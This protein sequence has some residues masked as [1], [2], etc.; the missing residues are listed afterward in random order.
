MQDRHVAHRAQ[1]RPWRD[2][3]S[4]GT[5][6]TRALKSFIDGRGATVHSDHLVAAR[7]TLRLA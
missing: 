5:M 2:E 4:G 3:G 6:D 1:R 7:A